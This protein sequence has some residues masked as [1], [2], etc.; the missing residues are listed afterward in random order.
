ML[1]S[2]SNIFFILVLFISYF[3]FV[4]AREMHFVFYLRNSGRIELNLHFK[5]DVKSNLKLVTNAMVSAFLTIR[6]IYLTVIND[7][8]IK[9]S[10]AAAVGNMSTL[11]LATWRFYPKYKH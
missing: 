1:L 9:L 11:F 5:S 7:F 3:K 6:I 8:K 10:H 2:D 4:D